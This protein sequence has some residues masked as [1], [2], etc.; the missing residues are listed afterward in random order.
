[1]CSQYPELRKDHD[2]V[3]SAARR[4]PTAPRNRM[5]QLLR[6]DLTERH[7]YATITLHSIS[8]VFGRPQEGPGEVASRRI[9]LS[10]KSGGCSKEL[11]SHR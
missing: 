5:G 3:Q 8:V 11:P 10:R 2:P 4:P 6:R 7:V 1:M 9:R